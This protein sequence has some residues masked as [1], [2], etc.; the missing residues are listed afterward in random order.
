MLGV[1]RKRRR[2]LRPRE[3]GSL[4]LGVGGDLA[5]LAGHQ[6]VHGPAERPG[7]CSGNRGRQMTRELQSDEDAGQ[8]ALQL[9]PMHGLQ[10]LSRR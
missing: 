10:R 4:A 1:G 3:P 2:E 9:T 7:R 6:V 8:L 5:E